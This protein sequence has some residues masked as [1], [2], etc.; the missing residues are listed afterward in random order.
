LK[1]SFV[2]AFSDEYALG[3][4][5]DFLENE[6]LKFSKTVKLKFLTVVDVFTKKGKPNQKS[7]KNCS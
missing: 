2:F 3:C 5:Q 6:M 1:G 4:R 7:P